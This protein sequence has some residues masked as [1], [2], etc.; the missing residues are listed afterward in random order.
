M[1]RERTSASR[2][3]TTK[4]TPSREFRTLKTLV[5]LLVTRTVAVTGGGVFGVVIWKVTLIAVDRFVAGRLG[6]RSCPPASPEGG[7]LPPELRSPRESRLFPASRLRGDGRAARRLI[8]D[9]FHKLINYVVGHPETRSDNQCVAANA[10]ARL[11]VSCC[12][13]RCQFMC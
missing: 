9:E 10:G 6:A 3:H 12:A 8:Y 7:R 1:Q 4:V 5:A 13:G 2:H 11:E